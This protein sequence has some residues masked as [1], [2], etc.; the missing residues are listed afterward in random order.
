MAAPSTSV[1]PSNTIIAVAVAERSLLL[2]PGP[3]AVFVIF[4]C[5]IHRA[6]TETVCDP[7]RLSSTAANVPPT[8]T[9]LSGLRN[10]VGAAPL[11]RL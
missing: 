2:E 10:V 7:P 4:P 8:V 9:F 3:L 5:P 11:T 1:L 6:L